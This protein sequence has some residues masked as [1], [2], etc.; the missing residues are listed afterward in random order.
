MEYQKTLEYLYNSLPMYHRVGMAAYKED[1]TNTVRLMQA[2]NNPERKFKSIH[3]AGT[4]GKGSVSHFL[5]SILQNSGYKVGLYTSPH[6]VDFRE[7]IR[8]NGQMIS[9]EY[10]TNFVE[11]NKPL[12]QK[13]SPSFFEMTVAMAFNYF[14]EQNVDIAVIEVGMG[15]RLDSTNVI[16][17]VLSIITN[18]SIDHTQYLGNTIEA[19]AR[20]KAG[21]IKRNVPVVIGQTQMECAHVFKEKAS[22]MNSDIYFADKNFTLEETDKSNS[23]YLHALIYKNRNTYSLVKTPLSGRYQ[24]KNLATVAQATDILRQIGYKISNTAFAIGIE[25]VVI[26][27]GLRGRWEIMSQK[28]TIVCETA[29]NEDGIRCL[30]EKINSL[31]INKLHI[32]YG[33]VN[34]KDY[35]KILEM[36]PKN[37]N[38]YFCKPSVPRGLD[39][40]ELYNTAS[41]IGLEGNKYESLS[42]AMREAKRRMDNDDILIITGSIF[43]VAD[44]INLFDKR[45]V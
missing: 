32:I 45:A 11:A 24:M 3:V 28:P 17:P 31:H 16:D 40:D 27:T 39:T 10:V 35:S 14:A 41:G 33:C 21:I 30:I 25:S 5:A 20:E 38:Y 4:N 29:H 22:E 13:I 36:L 9:E 43:L 6:L 1:I 12:F 15:G 7:R 2:L 42:L 34:D 19:I 18:I 23:F 37:A 26:D 8:I 44:A